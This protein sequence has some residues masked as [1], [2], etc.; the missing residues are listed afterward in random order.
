MSPD[1]V[2]KWINIIS[3]ALVLENEPV[4]DVRVSFDGNR[5]VHY[6][7]LEFMAKLTLVDKSRI[8]SIEI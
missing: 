7:L 8:M 1:S 2:D 5:V 6:V 3:V 4:F